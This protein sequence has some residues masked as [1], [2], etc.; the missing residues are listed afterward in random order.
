MFINDLLLHAN[1]YV[2]ELSYVLCAHCMALFIWYLGAWTECMA[3][4][5]RGDCSAI[6]CICK[7]FHTLHTKVT[8]LEHAQLNILQCSSL[9][10]SLKNTARL[11]KST[12]RQKS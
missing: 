4:I 2:G 11:T 9:I 7:W 8:A 5:F 12:L 1:K 10:Y 3:L 6:H